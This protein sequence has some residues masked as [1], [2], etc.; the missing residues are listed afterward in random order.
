MDDLGLP[1]LLIVDDRPENILALE[2]VLRPLPVKLISATS[3]NDALA[4]VLEQAFALILLDVQMPDMDG[5][6]TAELIRSNDDSRH[7]PIIFVTAISK[8][9]RFVFKGYEAGAVD[10][11]FKPIDPEVLLGKV[12]IFLELYRQRA[13][14][15][16]VNAELKS[17]NRQII[18][19]QRAVIEEERLKVLLQMAGATAH[20]LNQP[21][22]ALL[23]NIELLEMSGDM[24]EKTAKHIGNVKAAGERIGSIIRK[25]Q[26]IHHTEIGLSVG[27]TPH[28]DLVHPLRILAVDADQ[29]DV[30]R[31]EGFLDGHDQVSVDRATTVAD[32]LERLQTAGF[33][34]VFTDYLFEDGTAFDIVAGLEEMRMDTPVVVITGQGDELLAAQMIQIGA[35]EYLPKNRLDTELLQTTITKTLEKARLKAEIRRAQDKMAEMSTRDELTQLANRRYFNEVLELKFQRGRRARNDLNLAILDLD[36]FK[37]VNDRYGHPAGDEVLIRVSRTLRESLRQN[38]TACRYGGEEFVFLLSD[39]DIQQARMI[40]E[41]LRAAIA[42][43][44]VS[45]GQKVIR[46]TASIGLSSSA[47]ASTPQELLAR[48][49][50]AL[51]QAKKA[52]RNMVVADDSE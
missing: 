18:E 52:G 25:I 14:L 23:G 42:D 49:D 15:L 46:I 38:D 45:Y 13:R 48:A 20:E 11:L 35:Y 12:N 7:I 29:A 37:S 9:E 27:D 50:S 16:K 19:Q 24:P 41:R 5:F 22:M 1:K 47:G 34:L 39:I 2:K 30:D 43:L 21:L 28:L 26:G 17:A 44:N 36:H 51:Y 3:G 10:Y 31:I 4:L 6:E 32:A 8:E 40:C 33:D